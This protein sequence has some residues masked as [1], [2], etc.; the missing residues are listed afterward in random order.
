MAAPD[1]WRAFLFEPI[2]TMK[3][4]YI[5]RERVGYAPV[6]INPARNIGGRR[7]ICLH[8]DNARR[9]RAGDAV[10]SGT[11]AGGIRAFMDTFCVR[12][13]VFV[14]LIPFMLLM[15]GTGRR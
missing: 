8:D 12:A 9:A 3:F 11:A 1:H 5:A 10:R 4:Y 15:R 13:T 14:G 2:N 6:M 7:G